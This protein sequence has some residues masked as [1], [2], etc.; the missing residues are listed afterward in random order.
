[1]QPGSQIYA[2]IDS[3]LFAIICGFLRVSKF[4]KIISFPLV[5]VWETSAERDRNACWEGSLH[6]PRGKIW[7]SKQEMF[8]KSKTSSCFPNFDASNAWQMGHN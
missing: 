6:L 5:I 2:T 1:M 4:K 3:Y 7:R 8:Y